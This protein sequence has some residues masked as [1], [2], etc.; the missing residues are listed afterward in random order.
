TSNTS[1]RGARVAVIVG[2]EGGFTDAEAFAIESAGAAPCSLGATILRTETAG[3]AA[4]AM[5]LYELEL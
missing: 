3:P 5:I 1:E 4:V 2:P